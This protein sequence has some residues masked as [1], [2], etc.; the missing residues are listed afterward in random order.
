MVVAVGSVGSYGF[1]FR[2]L[3]RLG[4]RAVVAGDGWGAVGACLLEWVVF[5]LL[6]VS[7]R[8][9]CIKV[10]VGGRRGW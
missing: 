3:L 7:C 9:G 4:F 8:S 6:R 10:G 2:W 1:S 5:Y